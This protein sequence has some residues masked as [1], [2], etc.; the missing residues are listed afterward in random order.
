MLII[1]KSLWRMISGV[2]VGGQP[3]HAPRLGYWV[4]NV[5]H[6]RTRMIII[7][8]NLIRIQLRAK[9]RPYT[10]VSIPGRCSRCINILTPGDRC[11]L[12]CCPFSA[13]QAVTQ[14]IPVTSRSYQ[15]HF[16]MVQ[17]QPLVAGTNHF[18]NRTP[19]MCDNK[20]MVPVWFQP[21]C[22]GSI[23]YHMVTNMQ[24]TYLCPLS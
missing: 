22:I 12:Q 15:L 8:M 10:L 23:Y 4:I 24:I 17:G 16:V 13:S 14:I 9:L 5:R 3:A 6:I 18:N 21:T 2:K 1:S 11:S 19:N 7:N 20:T